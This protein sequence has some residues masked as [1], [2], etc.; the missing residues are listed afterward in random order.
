MKNNRQ[1]RCEEYADPMHSEWRGASS[2][3]ANIDRWSARS[4]SNSIHAGNVGKFRAS[5]GEMVLPDTSDRGYQ[6]PKRKTIADPRGEAKA[7]RNHTASDAEAIY[8]P[9]TRREA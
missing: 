4:A 8:Y 6:E 9:K 7:D 3:K 2:D 5:N 1:T